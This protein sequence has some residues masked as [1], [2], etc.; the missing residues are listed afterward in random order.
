MPL[1]QIHD[2]DKAVRDAAVVTQTPLLSIPGIG[3]TLAAIILAEV[4]D[5]HRF[6]FPDR[7][8]AFAALGLSTCQS[9]K[10][11]ASWTPM[12]KRGSR[13]LRRALMQASRLVA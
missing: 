1:H 3:P 9:V 10:F 12:A 2:L 11:T 8:L 5:F 6:S 7:L 13:Y 4:G